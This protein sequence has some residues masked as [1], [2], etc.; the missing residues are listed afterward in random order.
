L[1]AIKGSR[2]VIFVTHNPNI[3]VLG[4]AERVFVFSSD[5]QHSTLKQVGT[6]D[7][8]REQIERILEGGRAARKYKMKSAKVEQHD[9]LPA[10]R[11][12]RR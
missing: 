7:E 4:D 12:L 2:Q 5:G 8:C 6:V 10:S 9:L 1:R 3:P 11:K